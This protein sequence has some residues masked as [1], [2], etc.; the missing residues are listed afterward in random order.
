MTPKAIPRFL[1]R[2]AGDQRGNMTVEALMVFPLLCWAYLGTFV[3]FDGF[4][5]YSVNIR[6]AY[7]MGDILSRQTA[8]I[9]PEFM[10]SM[11]AL[12]DVLTDTDEA[13]RVRVTKFEY[14]KSDDSFQRVWSEVRG[15]G[16]PRHTSATLA[17]MRAQIPT[18]DD[19]ELAVLTETWMDYTPPM[20][21]GLDPLTFTQVVVTRPR[22]ALRFCWNS[23]DGGGEATRT[24]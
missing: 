6:A 14:R 2:F 11:S 10:D 16:V 13:T 20:N 12:Q 17:Q 19:G 7:T 15:D 18:L 21:V 1:R 22:Y 4:H 3:F 9:T 5:A 23:V 8:D 24:C